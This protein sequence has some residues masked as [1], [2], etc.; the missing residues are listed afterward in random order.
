MSELWREAMIEAV[1]NTLKRIALFLPNLLAMLTLLVIGL[2]IGWIAKGLLLR[3]LRAV[4]FDPLCE[5]WGLS[6]ALLK[7][8]VKRPASQLVGRLSFWVIFLLFAFMGID[9]LNLPAAAHL[10]TIALRFLPQLLT[11]L[12]LL[13]AG[14]LLANFLAQGALIAAVNAQIQGARLIATLIRWGVLIFTAATVLTQLGI[15]KE[16]VVA[17]FSITFGGV[18]LALAL[19][20]GLGGRDLAKELL[21]RRLR[22]EKERKREISHL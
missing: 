22:G 6:Q 4:R 2:G 21:E 3:I 20:F 19:A 11:A 9:A 15:A 10:T 13:L 7:A 1:R 12:L 14:W 8:G 17:A 5:R 18:I 16:I